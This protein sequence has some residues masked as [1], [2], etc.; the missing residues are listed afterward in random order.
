MLGGI[1][2][3]FGVTVE[4]IAKWNKL[5]NVTIIHAG[6]QYVIYPKVIR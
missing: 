5:T 3:R 4:D 2:Q 6:D 1:A